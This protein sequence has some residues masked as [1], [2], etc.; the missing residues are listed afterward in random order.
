M[1]YKWETFEGRQHRHDARKEP[2]ITLGPKGTIYM[3]RFAFDALGGPA[4]V[5]ILFDGNRRVIGL[6]P[7]DPR[8]RNAFVIKDH[9]TGNYKRLSI[10]SFC[11]H[12]RIKMDRTYMFDGVE[13]TD[14]GVML[15]DMAKMIT[16]SRGAR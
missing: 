10:S 8:K 14:D 12:V 2:R 4:A 16:V 9:G 11:Q 5:E 3:N 13:L 6:K 15:L 1:N 7:T